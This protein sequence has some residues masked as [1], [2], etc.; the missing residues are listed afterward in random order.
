M[1]TFPANMSEQAGYWEGTW[2]GRIHES[3][4]GVDMNQ[5]KMCFL[6]SEI[7][8]R[9]Y[10]R[11]LDVLEVGCGTGI[12]A[13]VLKHDWP[14]LDKNWTGIDLSKKAVAYAKRCGFNAEVA[15]IYNYKPGRKFDAF[16][17]MDVLE[18]LENHRAVG[19]KVRELANKEYWIFGNIPLYSTTDH[20]QHCERP[21]DREALANFLA[22]CGMKKFWQRIYGAFGFPYMIF[23][24]HKEDG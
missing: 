21:M 12:H 7:Y 23:E 5:E 17:F 9:P 14:S 6:I 11:D 4:K 10:Y 18:H 15:S 24:A 8:K 13:A 2:D 19:A 3:G 22:Y 16:W 1:L 20:A